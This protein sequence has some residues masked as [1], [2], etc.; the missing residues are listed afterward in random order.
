MK[1]QTF[2]KIKATTAELRGLAPL[3]FLLKNFLIDIAILI[4]YLLLKSGSN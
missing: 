4:L 2:A 1:M 3:T